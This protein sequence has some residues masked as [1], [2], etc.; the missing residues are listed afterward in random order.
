MN[1]DAL[2]LREIQYGSYGVLKQI[3]KICEEHGWR[4]FLTY[5]SLI[6]AIRNQGIIP[7]DDDI[8]IMM[9]RPDYEAFKAYYIQNQEILYPYKLFD[10]SV[11][12]EY[13]HL[14]SRVSDQRYHLI[15]ENE[16]DYGIGLFV[17]IYPLDGVGNNKDKAIKL[18]KRT[19]KLASLCFLT[20]RKSFGQDNTNSIYKMIIKLPAYIW[21]K[22]MG[23]KHYIE[24]LNKLAKTYSFEDS[25]YVACVAWPVGKKYNRERDVFEKDLFRTKQIHFEDGEFPIPIGYD[26]FLRI[27]YGDYMTA[28]SESGKKTH[29]TY[30]AFKL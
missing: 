19:K 15:F 12:E 8:D 4:W 2:T 1:Q 11:V 16:I 7:W 27:T 10:K 23:N 5:G 13:P 18:T 22:T 30:Q 26:T 29:H 9:P 21:A 20:S 3:S 28:P 25:K 6:G 14:I 24:R 17:D